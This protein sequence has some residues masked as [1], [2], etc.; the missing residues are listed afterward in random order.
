MK[1]KIAFA[2]ISLLT[3][4]LIGLAA[5]SQ[6]STQPLSKQE[7]VALLKQVGGR[8]LTQTDVVTEVER[9][10]VGFAVDEKVLSELRQQGARSF[11]LDV[12]KRAGEKR[13]QPLLTAVEANPSAVAVDE[14]ATEKARAEILAKLP[15]IEQA[16]QH[17]LDYAKELPN[18]IVTQ[19]VRRF[20]QTP[21]S[22]DWQAEDTLEVE[23]TYSAEKGEQFKLLRINGKSTQQ[24]YDALSGS[25]STGEF[26]TSLASLFNPHSKAEFTEAKKDILNGRA[27]L[28]YDFV[29]KKANSNSIIA[30]KKS[31]Q[32]TVAGY[33]GSVWID[34]ETKQVLR[35]EAAS[36]GMP[37]NF[38][39]SLAENAVEYDWITIDGERY[40]LPIR[41]E[42]ILG[43]DRDRVYTRNV[44]EF[45]NYQKFLAKIKIE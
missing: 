20:L 10:G 42:L 41:A 9:R 24:S 16:R 17:A 13:G 3:I 15:L 1:R 43:S 33:R 40:L 18:F 14:E 23:L 27:T 28:I 39:I 21:K 4:S 34:S 38:P 45:R 19:K 32:K 7:I 2:L 31:G 11:L 44:I 8:S 5:Q 25:T 29:V 37:A 26:G 22:K 36:E 30:D 6:E 12:I 35:L